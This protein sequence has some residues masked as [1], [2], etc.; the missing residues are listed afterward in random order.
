MFLVPV[1]RCVL[2]SLVVCSLIELRNRCAS[3]QTKCPTC[4]ASSPSTA[5]TPLCLVAH[6]ARA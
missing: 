6:A 2:F 4:T 3:L 5:G 1:R